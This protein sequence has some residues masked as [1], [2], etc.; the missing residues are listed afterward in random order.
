[1]FLFAILAII[2][3]TV[4]MVDSITQNGTSYLAYYFDAHSIIVFLIL[5]IPILI[6]TGLIKNFNHAFGLAFG[7]RKANNLMELKRAEEAVALVQKTAVYGGVFSSLFYAVIFL[8]SADFSSF[9][10]VGYF[11]SAAL[12]NIVYAAAINLFLLPV[13]TKLKLKIA[14]YMQE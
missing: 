11:L 9:N 10:G 6:S 5:V 12:T 3:S 2:L 13:Y 4:Y 1:M 7:K 14:E 8:K